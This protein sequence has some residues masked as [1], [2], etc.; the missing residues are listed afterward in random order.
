MTMKLTHLRVYHLMFATKD[1]KAAS[2][3]FWI[4]QEI[5]PP[6]RVSFIYTWK[7]YLAK[8]SNQRLHHKA[9]HSVFWSQCGCGPASYLRSQTGWRFRA[10]KKSQITVF[11]KQK[12]RKKTQKCAKMWLR[13]VETAN[14]HHIVSQMDRWIYILHS[15]TFLSVHRQTENKYCSKTCANCCLLPIRSHVWQRCR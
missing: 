7:R 15:L 13:L 12:R 5:S 8:Q 11:S 1:E 14:E 10:A 3:T 4:N 2:W 6:T 9:H